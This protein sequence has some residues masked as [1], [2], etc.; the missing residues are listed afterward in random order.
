V[1]TFSV[2]SA[3]LLVI[4]ALRNAVGKGGKH[5]LLQGLCIV[6]GAFALLGAGAVWC[7]E[8]SW[9]GLVAGEPPSVAGTYFGFWLLVGMGLFAEALEHGQRRGWILF[10]AGVFGNLVGLIFFAAPLSLAVYA[11]CVLLLF[12][13]GLVYLGR[14]M[15][16]TTLFKVVLGVGVCV[17]A[18]AAVL[19]YNS[20]NPVHEKIASIFPLDNQWNVLVSRNAVRLNAALSIWQEY[21]WRGCGSDGFSHFA[22]LVVSPEN[23][24]MIETDRACVYNDGVQFLCEYGVFGAGMLLVALI[25]LLVPIFARI[26]QLGSKAGEKGKRDPVV[27]WSPTLVGGILALF[28]CGL[29]SMVASPF[30]SSAV[31]LAWSCV[32]A[33]LPAFISEKNT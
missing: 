10:L 28:L 7:E 16:K 25:T 17:A 4:V 22:G 24:K 15:R 18:L 20:Q 30:R 13:Y 6:S 2:L 14:Y 23:W 19:A 11:L 32:M 29:E 5:V 27:L 31:L 33:A 9:V 21:V 12:V 1:S 26:R 8:P 3:C